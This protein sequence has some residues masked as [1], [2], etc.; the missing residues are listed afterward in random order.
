RR[1]HFP[2]PRRLPV[3]MGVDVDE[4]GGDDPAA[5]VD[6]LAAR[7]DVGADRD[8]AVA[9]DRDI[10]DKGLRARTIDD[11]AAANHQNMHAACP[12]YLALSFV[13]GRNLSWMAEMPSALGPSL[14][15]TKVAHARSVLCPLWL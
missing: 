9:V 12:D 3:I 1:G 5:R 7:A 11:R 15:A 4:A 14:E 2:V 13:A 6:L 8:D 10:G